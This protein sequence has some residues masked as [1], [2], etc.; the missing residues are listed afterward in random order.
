VVVELDLLEV[1]FVLRVVVGGDTVVDVRM[2]VGSVIGVVSTDLAGVCMVV[3]AEG[4][5]VVGLVEVCI[6][7]VL[8]VEWLGAWVVATGV[9]TGTF[10]A[11]VVVDGGFRVDVVIGLAV[12]V[13]GGFPVVAGIGLALVGVR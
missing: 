13:D 6:K 2:V 3:V 11:V 10:F 12:V 7:G 1:E 9:L 5:A 8:V 4:I